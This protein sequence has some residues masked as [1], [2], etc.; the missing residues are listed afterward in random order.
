MPT[1]LPWHVSVMIYSLSHSQGR[2]TVCNQSHP[3][4]H[5][6]LCIKAGNN[7]AAD[8][9]SSTSHFK[10][11]RRTQSIF[12][13]KL[14]LRIYTPLHLQTWTETVGWDLTFQCD[15]YLSRKSGHVHQ[16]QDPSWPSFST[17]HS[18]GRQHR[19]RNNA[20][21]VA[22]LGNGHQTQQSDHRTV[23]FSME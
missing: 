23:Y 15:P 10:Q 22:H 2:G 20:S 19:P 16:C 18:R 3:L 5:Q 9:H 7:T 13:D 8:T 21:S 12:L 1:L 14:A 17:S 4:Q 11:Q 6:I